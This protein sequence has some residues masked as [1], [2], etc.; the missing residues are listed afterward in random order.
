MPETPDFQKIADQL[1]PPECVAFVVDAFRLIWNARGAAD[2]AQIEAAFAH[3]HP[4][5]KT[6]DQAIRR[7]DR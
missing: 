7:L 6:L 1:V 5:V 2:I 3:P 4:A